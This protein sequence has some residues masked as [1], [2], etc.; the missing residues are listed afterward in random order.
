MAAFLVQL[1]EFVAQRLLVGGR[2]PADERKG[3]D[4]VEMKRVRNGDELAALEPHEEWLVTTWLVDVIDEAQALQNVERSRRI[5][6]PIGVPADRLLTRDLFNALHP[7][8]DEAALRVGIER[9]AILPSASVS[10]R[11]MPTFDDLARELGSFVYGL[12]NH[13]R[14][15]LYPMLVE[16]IH[17]ARDAFIYAVFEE[18]V[19]GQV[20]QPLLDRIG[21][22]AASAGKR[23]AAGLEHQGQAHRQARAI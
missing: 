21:D 20:G 10:D 16:Q 12:P 17:D 9:V 14:G 5:A 4:V 6:H 1:I 7:I 13:E 2:I 15:H 23:L 3:H 11:F 18:R 22:D 8:G 19:R